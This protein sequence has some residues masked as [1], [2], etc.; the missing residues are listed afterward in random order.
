M[1]KNNKNIKL[2]FE[3]RYFDTPVDTCIDRDKHREK[4][5][6]EDVI[7]SMYKKYVKHDICKTDTRI[8]KA[9]DISLPRCI[10]CDID[11]T[12]SLMN[13][14]SP[15][16]DSKIHTDKPNSYVVNLVKRIANINSFEHMESD[17]EINN[18][19]IIMSGRMDKCRPQTEQW[20]KD[21]NIPYDILLMRKTDDFRQDSIVKKE[22]YN[23]HI[24]DQFYVDFILD[25]RDQVVEMWRKEGLLCLQVYYG[26]F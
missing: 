14:R 5:V 3:E 13:G 20:L 26:N 25:D 23:N 11:G 24:K 22:L 18:A 15:Y 19:I 10:I 16:D 17:G 4:S 1:I 8:I 12:L 6:G 7:R 2:E 21:N 9:Q